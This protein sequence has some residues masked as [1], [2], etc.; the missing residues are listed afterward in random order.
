MNDALR[1]QVVELEAQV[2]AMRGEVVARHGPGCGCVQAIAYQAY[3]V[4]IM[5]TSPL[6]PR[7]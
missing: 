6:P 2:A 7:A 4:Q 1:H 5:K 3:A